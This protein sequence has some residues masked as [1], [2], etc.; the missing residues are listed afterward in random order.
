MKSFQH[1]Q[2]PFSSAC[3]NIKDSHILPLIDL[4]PL[5]TPKTIVAPLCRSTFDS[6]MEAQCFQ[7]IVD[8][9]NV[10]ATS[11]KYPHAPMTSWFYWAYNPD[12]G[13]APPFVPPS[14]AQVIRITEAESELVLAADKAVA[15][16]M[17]SMCRLTDLRYWATHCS[18]ASFCCVRAQSGRT[19]LSS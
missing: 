18:Q 14:G 19:Y 12:S 3:N 6:I 1:V 17:V 7:G 8:W 15:D 10:A 4:A 11:K 5:R 16:S 13:G 2:G 9:M